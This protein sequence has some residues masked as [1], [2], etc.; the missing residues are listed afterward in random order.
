MHDSDIA[1]AALIVLNDVVEAVTK[2][3]V[4]AFIIAVVGSHVQVCVLGTKHT[5]VTV[6]RRR[7]ILFKGGS[8]SDRERDVRAAFSEEEP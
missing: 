1:T 3:H 2:R 4:V 8:M 5:V 7:I 6:P